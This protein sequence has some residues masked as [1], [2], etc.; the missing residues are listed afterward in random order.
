MMGSW[1]Y[2]HMGGFGWVGMILLWILM[3]LA[4]IW[5]WRTLDISR[6]LRDGGQ[7]APRPDDALR[8]VRERYARGEIGEEEFEKMK[9]QLS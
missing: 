3:A 6:T 8:I 4:V 9:R 5:L 1:G 7:K 2:G